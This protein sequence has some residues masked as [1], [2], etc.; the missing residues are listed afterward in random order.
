MFAVGATGL[1]STVVETFVTSSSLAV[2][3]GLASCSV[4]NGGS[5]K[6]A[7]VTVK[8]APLNRSLTSSFG[9]SSTL[10]ISPTTCDILCDDVVKMTNATW[11]PC[12]VPTSCDGVTSIITTSSEV[13]PKN[14]AN[15]LINARRE[16]SLLSRL[17][18]VTPINSISLVIMKSATKSL[19]S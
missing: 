2:G 15:P 8:P 18:T 4:T 19:S 10:L 11:T 1:P 16:T 7:F 14:I 6:V 5:W 9:S 12:D 3:L 17:W 13:M